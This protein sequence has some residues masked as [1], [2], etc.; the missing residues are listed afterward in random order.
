MLPVKEI[1]L[2]RQVRL[3]GGDGGGEHGE[4]PT[5]VLKAPPTGGLSERDEADLALDLVGVPGMAGEL[6]VGGQVPENLHAGHPHDSHP[7]G[8]LG[9]RGEVKLELHIAQIRPDPPQE[10]L[11]LEL[12][13]ADPL[14]ARSLGDGQGELV[15][16][17]GLAPPL[18][19][20]LHEPG[21]RENP[22]R[23]LAHPEEMNLGPGYL[24]EVLPVHRPYDRFGAALGELKTESLPG[25]M[26]ARVDVAV[27]GKG[28]EAQDADTF[29]AYGLN[30]TAGG[31]GLVGLGY[32]PGDPLEVGPG[33]PP[34]VVA[35]TFPS[36]P[37]R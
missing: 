34:P 8:L 3:H 10:Q 6:R 36:G 35:G 25:L 2:P 5:V 13:R 27:L 16:G 24:K 22:E 12:P 9:P 14:A 37:H 30:G 17:Q 20:V 26:V 4:D 18:A 7:S 33:N 23:L 11:S 15:G 19:E 31:S 28:L 21:K 32:A 1:D 29:L